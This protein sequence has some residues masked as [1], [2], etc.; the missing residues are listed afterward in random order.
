MKYIRVLPHKCYN[1]KVYLISLSF[2]ENN[3]DFDVL[4]LD[5]VDNNFSVLRNY[6]NGE[7]C[8]AVNYQ[9]SA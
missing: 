6:T 7:F 9:R 5:L 4:H 8:E 2:L 1:I 3:L